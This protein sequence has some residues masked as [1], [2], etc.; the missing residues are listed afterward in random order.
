ME[1]KSQHPCRDDTSSGGDG[2]ADS[3]ETARRAHPPCAGSGVFLLAVSESDGQVSFP[4]LDRE[5]VGRISGFAGKHYGIEEQS[6]GQYRRLG[7]NEPAC[8]ERSAPCGDRTLSFSITDHL[9]CYI[10]GREGGVVA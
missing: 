3:Q 1:K 4:V 10:G 7:R 8:P 9:D 5:P 2:R 6:S